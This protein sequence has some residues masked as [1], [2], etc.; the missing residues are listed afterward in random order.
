M[1]DLGPWSGLV[2]RY[3]GQDYELVS[4]KPYVTKAGTES[5][6]LEWRSTCPTCST[7]FTVTSGKVFA[8]PAQR[9]CNACKR[10]GFPVSVE[11]R[12]KEATP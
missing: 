11:L 12:A 7:P 8:V 1:D 10:R 2:W 3:D 6:V 5:R 4:A 9:R